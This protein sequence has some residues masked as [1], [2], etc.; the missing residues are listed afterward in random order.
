MTPPRLQQL[1]PTR[2]VDV[3]EI[4][5][6][7]IDDGATAGFELVAW[8]GM[9]NGQAIAIKIPGTHTQPYNVTLQEESDQARD[10]WLAD[11]LGNHLEGVLR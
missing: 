8:L 5:T 7:S 2:W 10:T 4:V 3:D 9:R 1:E 11:H 6:V